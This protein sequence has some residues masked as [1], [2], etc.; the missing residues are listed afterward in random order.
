M[1]VY[2]P[3]IK[4]ESV[5]RSRPLTPFWE[6]IR[7]SGPA[8]YLLWICPL[9]FILALRQR[10]PAQYAAIDGSA[11]LQIIFSFVCFGH[12]LYIFLG[13]K[14]RMMKVIFKP[15]LIFLFAYII[16]CGFSTLWSANPLYT[17]YRA[18]E[19]LTYLLLTTLVCLNLSQSCSKQDMAEWIIL[20][21]VWSLFCAIIATAKLVGFGF[22]QSVNI[23]RNGSL[24]IAP[25]FF[26]A[27]FISK[28]R[29]FSTVLIVFSLLSAANKTY[30]GLAF[31]LFPGLAMGDSKAK[32]MFPFVLGLVILS[33]LIFGLTTSIQKTLFYG[34]EGI[35]LE[36]MT[37][38]DKVWAYSIEHGMKHPFRGYGFV[39][40]ENDA[41]TAGAFRG[42]ISTHNVFMSS[43][44]AVGLLG[45]ILMA[46]FFMSLFFSTFRVGIPISWRSGLIGT[47]IMAFTISNSAPGLGGR[48]YGSWLSVVLVSAFI[49]VLAN[50]RSSTDSFRT[51]ELFL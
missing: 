3:K 8:G 5:Q 24:D 40:G 14:W 28:K 35:G 33:L 39:T 45:P 23:F 48:V 15:P 20:W 2:I 34:E 51:R 7:R 12:V 43:F 31:G 4:S 36:Y 29:L 10:D 42:V 13:P 37:G 9:L 41:I 19:C 38:R 16:L 11:L 22:L 17:G 18:F 32:K 44:L 49:A 1:P 46:S 27:L 47:V 25:M 26:I 50:S 6:L 21:A 30:F